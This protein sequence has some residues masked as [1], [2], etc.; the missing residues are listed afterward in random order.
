MK[1]EGTRKTATE[2]TFAKAA[3]KDQKEK[4]KLIAEMD[5]CR[6]RL[7]PQ[8]ISSLRDRLVA[9]KQERIS[10]MS[11]RLGLLSELDKR[12]MEDVTRYEKDS[13][14]INTTTLDLESLRDEIAEADSIAKKARTEAAAMEVERTAPP[15]VQQIDAEPYISPPSDQTAKN[16]MTAGMAALCA[17]GAVLFAVSWWEWRA[18]R[19]DTVDEIV[20]GLGMTV[21]GTLPAWRHENRSR[22]IGK[23]A[24]RDLRF[25]SM[26]TESVDATRTMLLHAA[27]QESLRVVM[28]TSAVSGE[29]KTSLSTHLATS[30]A[31]ANRRTLLLDCDLR[32]PAAHRLFDLPLTPGFS[33]LLRGEVGIA[34]TIKATTI[35]GLWMITAGRCDERTLVSLSQ[36]DLHGIFD[37]L[38]AQFEFI[39]VDSSPVLPVADSLVI[40]QHVD[41]VLLSVLRDV[42]RIPMVYAAYQRLAV[43]GIRMLGAVVN[44]AREE[45]EGYGYSYASDYAYGYGRQHSE[46][47]TPPAPAP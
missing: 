38:K 24:Y 2:A 14:D 20:H 31:R 46:A 15:R 43:L 9:E 21:I 39:V 25:Q 16:L 45:V 4:D 5:R 6:E 17:F 30:L 37:Q 27:R 23:K 1:I 19:I 42:S 32:N 33:E 3:A 18:K 35:S 26:F 47:D 11:A 40:G 13:K 10:N 29:G 12:L 36:D 44:G 22:L 41:A 34:D 8:V 28:V 7:R